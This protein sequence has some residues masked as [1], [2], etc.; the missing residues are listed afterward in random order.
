MSHN[1]ILIIGTLPLPIGGVTIHTQRLITFLKNNNFKYNFFDYKKSHFTKGLSLFFK[2]KWIHVHANNQIFIIIITILSC[3]FFKKLIIT[4]HGEYNCKGWFIN[5][6]ESISLIISSVP[7]LLNELDYNRVKKINK[8]S[9]LISCFI[10]PMD[11]PSL[12]T[13]IIDKITNLKNNTKSI[14]CSNAYK[15]VYDYNGMEIYG[16]I[17]LIQFFNNN[18]NFGFILSDP[19]GTYSSYFDSEN[20]QLN[21]N[22]VVI[23]GNHSFFKVLELSDSFVRNTTTD[24]DSI[25]IREALFLNKKV[26]ATNCVNR[27]KDVI[28]LTKLSILIEDVYTNNSTH[29]SIQKNGAIELLK[30]YKLK[31]KNI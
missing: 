22:I 23:N 24:G 5:L 14:F 29:N 3:I 16:I 12:S 28:L 18:A 20:I 25:S 17:E 2:S 13:T 26:F 21:N 6:L 7:I 9:L 10:P 31:L 27:P 30:L 4:V 11:E 19:S 8:N 1:K 15:L